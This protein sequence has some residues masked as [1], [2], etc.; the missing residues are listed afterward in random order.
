M[1]IQVS[2]SLSKSVFQHPVF[3]SH[4]FLNL[5]FVSKKLKF[6][7]NSAKKMYALN[8]YAGNAFL[9]L[10]ISDFAQKTR[11]ENFFKTSMKEAVL[12]EA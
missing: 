8:V 7:P 3:L 10:K 1:S 9:A 6:G 4:F 2:F 11:F 12:T 5:K